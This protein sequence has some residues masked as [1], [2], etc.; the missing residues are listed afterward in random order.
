KLKPFLTAARSVSVKTRLPLTFVPPRMIGRSTVSGWKKSF[1]DVV[2]TELAAPKLI[3]SPVRVMSPLTVDNVP[4]GENDR[5]PLAALIAGV[6]AVGAA[7]P[8]TERL[9]EPGALIA[10][11]FST[12]MP[13]LFAP[14]PPPVPVTETAPPL[15]VIDE[16]LPNTTTP[17]FRP[18]AVEP[19]VPWTVT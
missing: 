2:L 13:K 18:P 9:A 15:E 10:P 11:E 14:D 12:S 16:P 4:P 7:V 5:I 6:L 8:V 17:M 19:P 3:W 1:P